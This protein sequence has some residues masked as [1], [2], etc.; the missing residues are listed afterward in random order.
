VLAG[1]PQY[2]STTGKAALD[3][4]G[5]TITGLG[6]NSVSF[7]G[8]NLDY[9]SISST[10][11]AAYLA[12]ASWGDGGYRISTLN[13]V[14]NIQKANAQCKAK[15]DGDCD[16]KFSSSSVIPNISLTQRDNLGRAV[17]VIHYK[18]QN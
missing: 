10:Y 5:M 4:S 8:S 18:Q 6:T 12:T 7:T 16:N 2:T 13:G 11:T 1:K 14:V 17:T 3:N 9:M 15:N